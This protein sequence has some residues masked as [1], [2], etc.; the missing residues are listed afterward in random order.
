[1][2]STAFGIWVAAIPAA[3][4][5]VN[6]FGYLRDTVVTLAVWLPACMWGAG[7]MSCRNAN[8][9]SGV[10]YA[11]GMALLAM[12]YVALG[13]YAFGIYPDLQ[14]AQRQLGP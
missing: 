9:M 4:L 1:M 11:K 3:W 5:F 13:V 8:L 2:L 12:P 14:E 10:D 7:A 6:D